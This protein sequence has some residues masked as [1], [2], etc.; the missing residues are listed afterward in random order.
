M[1]PVALRQLATLQLNV[2]VQASC[3]GVAGCCGISS[4]TATAAA[5]GGAANVFDRNAKR[6]QR[7]RAAAAADADTYDYLKDRVYKRDKLLASCPCQIKVVLS[8]L[9]VKP[10]VLFW[11]GV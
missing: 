4:S 8:Q 5:G 6:K 1:F 9:F 10:P 3:H 7:N 2:L 11:C